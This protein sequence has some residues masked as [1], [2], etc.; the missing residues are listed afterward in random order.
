MSDQNTPASAAAPVPAPVSG[1][2]RREVPVVCRRLRT[3]AAFF[4][5]PDAPPWQAGEST[6][7]VYWC[8]GTMETWGPDE[9]LAHPH[10]CKENRSCFKAPA[11]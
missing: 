3:K 1:A 10:C 8:L 11:T 6:S 7:A 9:G 5:T 4:N 2:E